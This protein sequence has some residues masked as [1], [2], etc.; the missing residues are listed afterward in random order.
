M[1]H[2][3]A[4]SVALYYKHI[5]YPHAV[6]L[7]DTLLYLASLRFLH[8]FIMHQHT[9]IQPATGCHTGKRE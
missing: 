3:V 5:S 2:S 7:E 4:K 6:S 8:A 1:L 9:D